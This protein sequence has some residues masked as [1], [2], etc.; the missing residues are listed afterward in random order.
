MSVD[1]ST[2]GYWLV[3]ADG[4]VFSFGAP[5]LGSTGSIHLNRPV[6]GVESEIGTGY[7][8]VAS[9]GG[10]FPFGTSTFLGSLGNMPPSHVVV[11]I[12]PS[13][14][15]QGYTILDSAGGIDPFGN[16]GNFGSIL[17][18]VTLP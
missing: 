2:G 9:D 4:G 12:A 3:A 13:A 16:A 11:G 6:V 8:F 17:G 15:D 14:G 7:R 10:V 18:A 1:S 5:F